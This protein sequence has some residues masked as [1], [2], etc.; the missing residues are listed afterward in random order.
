[1]SEDKKQGQNIHNQWNTFPFACEYLDQYKTK[2]AECNSF[3]DAV[4][5]RHD[6]D[7][8]KNR[9]WFGIIFQVD[10]LYGADHKKAYNNKRGSS[11]YTGDHEEERRQKECCYKKNTCC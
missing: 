6:D 10:F 9:Q 11:G 2:H 7:G 4:R 5:K 1:M 3:G 8:K